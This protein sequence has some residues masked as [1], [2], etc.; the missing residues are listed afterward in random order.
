VCSNER[1]FNC[2]HGDWIGGFLAT[3]SIDG[4]FAP[5]GSVAAT[6]PHRPVTGERTLSVTAFT[7]ILTVVVPLTIWFAPLG[8]DPKA[9]KALAITA[10][11]VGSWMTH[12]QDVAFSGLMGLYLFWVTGVVSFGDAF[13]GFATTT[14]WFLFG[15]ILFGLMATKSGLARRLAF[16]VMQ[17]VGDT[18]PRLLLGIIIADFLLTFIVPSGIARVVIMAAIAAGLVEAF[19]CGRGSRIGAGVFIILVYTATIFDK[20]IIAGAASITARGLIERVGKVDVLWSQWFLAYLPCDII[21][22]FVAW[23]LTLWLYPPEVEKLPGGAAFL[24][25]ELKKM[26][27]LGSLE[28][29][30]IALFGLGLGLWMTDFLH[31][32]P[33][34]MIGLG[35]GLL[36][37]LPRVGVLDVED[38]KKVNVLPVFFVA[39]AI[40]MSY[41]LEHTKALTLLTDIL[42]AWTEPFMNN[43]WSSTVVLYWTAFVYHIVIGDEISMLATS[44][45]MLMNHANATGLNPL[46]IGMVW[47]FAAGGKIFLYQSAVLVV[48]YSYGYFTTR[49]L[50]KVGAALS[51]VQSIIVYL[52]VPFYWPLIGIR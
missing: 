27:P 33:S 20:M 50:L 34:P 46:A 52:L 1:R 10:F 13:H 40:S 51:I 9:Q 49:D 23:R 37:I 38:V 39:S 17:R 15:A 31:G 3:N 7:W 8:L 5:A 48:G 28:W 4:P 24:N 30:S 29:R 22:I 11:M 44:L 32:I 45:P 26:G 36:A 42:F 2:F 6:H 25:D 47:T 19:R 21:T 16:I 12:W 14:P 35:V 43:V 41:V 18:Y